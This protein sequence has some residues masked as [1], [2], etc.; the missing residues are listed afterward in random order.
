[1]EHVSKKISVMMVAEALR[2]GAQR[3]DVKGVLPVSPCSTNVVYH[4]M[5]FL[6]PF[7]A[8]AGSSVQLVRSA[9]CEC[10]SLECPCSKETLPR[11]YYAPYLYGASKYMIQPS[12]NMIALFTVSIDVYD[13][14]RDL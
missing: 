1:M 5:Q 6:P 11:L 8:A 4:I 10:V 3:R 12:Q 13:M 14:C 2:R 7:V 9:L